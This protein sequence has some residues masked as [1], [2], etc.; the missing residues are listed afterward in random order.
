M[1]AALRSTS[2]STRHS[3]LMG[4]EVNL[5]FHRHAQPREILLHHAPDD[6]EVEAKTAVGKHIAETRDFSPW[7][8]QLGAF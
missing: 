8:L 7:H 1:A 2:P 5:K 3:P 6:L 4:S